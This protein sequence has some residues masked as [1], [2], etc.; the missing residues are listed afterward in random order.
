MAK[1]ILGLL[2]PPIVSRV[3]GRVKI[4]RQLRALRAE[5]LKT[6]RVHLG[7]GPRIID[8][9]ANIDLV[10]AP[11]VI[12]WDLSAGL[13]APDN[14]LDYAYTEHFVEH[15]PPSTLFK[16]LLHLKRCLRPG[17]VLRISTPR[18]DA[19]VELYCKGDLTSFEDMGWLPANKCR[20]LN[21]AMR[22]WGHEF[23]YDFEELAGMLGRAGFDEIAQRSWQQ[24]P[25]EALAGLESRRYHDDLI[26]EARKR[27]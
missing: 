3:L 16:L 9:W 27:S 8:G 24:S 4:R 25:H 15:V 20:L 22:S 14:C 23:I 11:G 7:C 13:P 1:N 18:L 12:G 26:V 5:L 21:E 6:G 2:T 17:G 19:I 10:S